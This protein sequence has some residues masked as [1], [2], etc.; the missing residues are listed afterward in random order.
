MMNRILYSVSLRFKRTILVYFLIISYLTTF[1]SC[2]TT[3]SISVS[4]DSFKSAYSDKIT[5][6]KL[7]NGTSIDCMNK[8]IEIIKKSDS[9]VML[10]IYNRIS[11]EGSE[12]FRN[13]QIIPLNDILTL[14]LE[15][16]ETNIPLT[17]LFVSGIL[18]GFF[19]LIAL[20]IINSRSTIW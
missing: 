19:G 1:S 8:V 4:P 10:S 2:T 7:K 18:I 3:E 15:K 17:I 11:R 9:T 13:T 12:T 6:L 16:S 5:S 14:Q 20:L